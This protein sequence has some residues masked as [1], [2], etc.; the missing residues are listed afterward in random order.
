MGNVHVPFSLF[1]IYLWFHF[2]PNRHRLM[3]ECGC[4]LFTILLLYQRHRMQNFRTNKQT[5]RPIKAWM[6]L[7]SELSLV[8]VDL[9]WVVSGLHCG[10]AVSFLLP[11]P[12]TGGLPWSKTL[13]RNA[14]MGQNREKRRESGRRVRWRGAQQGGEKQNYKIHY[15]MFTDEKSNQDC[16]S[17]LYSISKL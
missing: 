15:K 12:Q 17:K 10:G 7:L 16:C 1:K 14:L 2:F 5:N 9:S 11:W 13:G 4:W 3:L 6:L 8:C